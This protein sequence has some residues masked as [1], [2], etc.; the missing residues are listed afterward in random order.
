MMTIETEKTQL[1][2]RKT[3]S[4]VRIVLGYDMISKKHHTV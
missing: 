1:I 4:F 3:H 2:I